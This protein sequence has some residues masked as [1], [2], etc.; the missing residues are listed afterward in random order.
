MLRNTKTCSAS[1]D[2]VHVVDI[3]S[4]VWKYTSDYARLLTWSLST[5]LLFEALELL[6]TEQAE[7]R[8]TRPREKQFEV[9]SDNFGWI[10]QQIIVASSRV[11]AYLSSVVEEFCSPPVFTWQSSSASYVHPM[12]QL[13]PPAT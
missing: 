7:L 12:F 6:H 9:L 3:P 5:F 4:Y 8:S 11:I 2:T 13:A 10:S 1:A